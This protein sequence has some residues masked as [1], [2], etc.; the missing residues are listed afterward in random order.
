MAVLGR[1]HVRET[2]GSSPYWMRGI[3]AICAT[4]WLT[5]AAG[6]TSAAQ[7]F[8]SDTASLQ[9]DAC[10]HEVDD[11]YFIARA[12]CINISDDDERTEMLMQIAL[13]MK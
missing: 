8:C 12:I 6:S 11:D 3:L 7:G 4:A 2:L 9:L 5:L 10:R 13:A 1:Q